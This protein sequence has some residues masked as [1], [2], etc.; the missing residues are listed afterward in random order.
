MEFHKDNQ[1]LLSTLP[2]HLVWGDADNVTPVTGSVGQFY[3]A[4]AND[5]D[6]NV[7]LNM[8][9][10]GHIPFDEIPECNE[11]MVQ[12]LDNVVAAGSSS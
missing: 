8:I 2:I 12:W 3:T 11:F 9:H 1:Q 7:S 5:A 10:S 4:L 6:S